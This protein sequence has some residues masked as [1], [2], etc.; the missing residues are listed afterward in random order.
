MNTLRFQGFSYSEF[1]LLSLLY[2]KYNIYTHIIYNVRANH[3]VLQPRSKCHTG[4]FQLCV[5]F[6]KSK[7]IQKTTAKWRAQN[8]IPAHTIFKTW[9][10][11]EPSACS[12][13]SRTRKEEWR[14]LRSQLTH[15]WLEVKFMHQYFQKMCLILNHRPVR[16][17]HTVQS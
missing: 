6:A 9:Q 10:D 8:K 12:S 1:T 15:R 13:R 5:S 3:M 7:S 11:F 16:N 17:R 4:G 2:Y 14:P